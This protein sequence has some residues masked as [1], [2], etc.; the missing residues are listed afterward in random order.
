MAFEQEGLEK[1]KMTDDKIKRICLNVVLIGKE[2]Q[3]DE[4]G[5]DENEVVDRK[6]DGDEKKE[7][8]NKEEKEKNED[9]KK[10]DGNG[11]KLHCFMFVAGALV[12]Y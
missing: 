4:V 1:I 6:N 3:E 12:C 8:K 2:V 11:K 5:L 9:K 7:E 10:E